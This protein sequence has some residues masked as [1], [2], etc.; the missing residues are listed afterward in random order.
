MRSTVTVSIASASFS[1]TEYAAARSVVSVSR[2]YSARVEWFFACLFCALRTGSDMSRKQAT[3]SVN[4]V[5]FGRRIQVGDM[6]G[7]F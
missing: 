4:H 5:A 3:L 7:M 6:F 2:V 1:G